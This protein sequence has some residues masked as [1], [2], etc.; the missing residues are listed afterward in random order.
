MMIVHEHK[1]N[2]KN[3]REKKIVNSDEF[4]EFQANQSRKL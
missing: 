2:K 4:S 1:V 3:K